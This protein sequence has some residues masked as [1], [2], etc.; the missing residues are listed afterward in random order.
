MCPYRRELGLKAYK[1]IHRGET[2]VIIGNGPSLTIGQINC[3][4]GYTTFGSNNIYRLPFTPDY[5]VVVDKEMMWSILPLPKDFIP[6]EM[7]VRAEARIEGNNPLYPIVVNGFSVDIDNFVVMGG[8][9]TYVIMQI[10]FYMGFKTMLLIGVDHHYK[11][12]GG[13]KRLRFVAKGDDPDHFKPAD[14]K[15][16]FLAG[17]T[18][19]PPELEGS[20]MY[21]GIAKQLFDQAGVRCVNL[22]P[23]SHLE[24]FKKDNLENWKCQ[25]Q[26][27]L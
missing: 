14:G 16:Y 11:K 25:P 8:T 3:L 10:A 24:V 9:V 20:T 6:K 22:T 23:G 13:Y 7:F 26:L 17:K 5:Y 4:S 21:Y 15:P 1:N 12:T 18:Y 2:C 27:D 19:N